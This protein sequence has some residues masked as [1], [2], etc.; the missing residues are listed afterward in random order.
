M[1]SY[2][3]GEHVEARHFAGLAFIGAGLAAIDGRLLAR[4]PEK[5]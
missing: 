1:G 2:G 4:R 5:D 3:L